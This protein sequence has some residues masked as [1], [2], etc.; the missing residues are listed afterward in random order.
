MNDRDLTLVVEGPSDV[1]F[2]KAI[3]LE[4]GLKNV[5]YFSGDGKISLVTLAR[6]I[7]VHEGGPVLVAMDADTCDEEQAEQARSLTR[8]IIQQL[9]PPRDFDVHVFIP[10]LEI[11]FFEAPGLLEKLLGKRIPAETMREGVAQPKAT[12]KRLVPSNGKQ[13]SMEHLLGM[14]DEKARASLLRA[15]QIDLLVRRIHDLLA[16]PVATH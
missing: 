5:R 6:N 7:L 16:A 15:P 8:F 14:M 9:A 13:F 2:M 1:T 12:L 11:S 10:E 4:I 3:C